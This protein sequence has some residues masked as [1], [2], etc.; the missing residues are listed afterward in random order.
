MIFLTV[1][2]APFLLSCVLYILMSIVCNRLNACPNFL[3]LLQSS[4]SCIL[5]CKRSLSRPDSELLY[6]WRLTANQFVLVPSPLET[7]DQYFFSTE[8]F[9]RSP[10]IISPLT[11]RWVCRLQLLLVPANAVFLGSES[12]G[13]HDHILQSQFPDF[14][15]LHGQVSIFISPRN[16]VSI[17]SPPTTRR[18]TVE[19]FD[20][21]STRISPV[22]GFLQNT[23]TFLSS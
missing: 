8:H 19:V 16:W 9:F 15:N 3:R 1:S 7:H 14:P 10:Y 4:L 23:Y 13:T 17:S 21:A 11:R 2:S 6:D 12:S 22:Q 18:A 20:P 5:P